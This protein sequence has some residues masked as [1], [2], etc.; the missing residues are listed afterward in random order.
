MDGVMCMWTGL[1]GDDMEMRKCKKCG[2][3]L[4]ITE[5]YKHGGVPATQ[6]KECAREYSKRYA[7]EHAEHYKKYRKRYYA[8]HR[9]EDMARSKAWTEANRDKHNAYCK[10]CYIEHTEDRLEYL[11]KYRA[12]NP[13]KYHATSRINHLVEKGKLT[14]PMACEVCGKVGRVEAHHADYSK[15]LDVKWVC[16]KCHYKLDEERREKERA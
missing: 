14:K 9:E 4:P 2:K 11:R 5:F 1:R 7:E 8:E 12:E 16:K 6:C 15:P 13:E 3:V 10:K